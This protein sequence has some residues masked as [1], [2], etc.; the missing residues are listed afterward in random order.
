MLSTLLLE[1]PARAQSADLYRD[2]QH[3]LQV[4]A[5]RGL[6]YR[7]K[8]P[9]IELRVGGRLHLDTV[10]AWADRTAIPDDTR[11]RRG[12][13]AF[14]ARAFD[15]WRLKIEYEF[16]KGRT[17]WRNLW[18][19]YQ[20][21]R[22]FAVTA[23]NFVVPFGLE[24]TASSNYATFLE[25]SLASALAPAFQTG[26]GVRT[27]GRLR[28]EQWK[29]R[30]TFGSAVYIEPLSDATLDRHRSEHWGI[31][32]RGTLAP[33]SRRKRLVHLGA[34]LEFRELDRGS[35]FRVR[36]RAETGLGD[37]L[38]N[39]GRLADVREV[40]T[41][42]L[43]SAALWGPVSLQSEY[44]RSRLARDDGRPNARFSGWSVQGRMDADR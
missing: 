26:I 2:D 30:W 8:D 28:G 35:R 27:R 6:R 39:T 34:A 38:L 36:S 7:H 22:R 11:V 4:S 19:R 31:A 15:D 23:G 25:R 40:I 42:G 12:R 44:M 33:I 29:P 43:E 18:L 3:R 1:T 32:A 41:F 9:R 21:N 37:A 13:L 14:S 17:G 10:E 5:N 20:P 24:D 16:A